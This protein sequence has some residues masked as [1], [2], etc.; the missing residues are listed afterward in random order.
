MLVKKSIVEN[1][2]KETS[3]VYKNFAYLFQ[4]PLWKKE[5]PNGFTVCPYFWMSMFSLFIFRPFV[6]SPIKY[7]LLPLIHA[8][9]KP[10]V[11]ADEFLF[12]IAKRILQFNGSYVKGGGVG[13]GIVLVIMAVAICG[14]LALI[15]FGVTS[16]Y[17]AVCSTALGL[18]VFYSAASF[19]G[20]LGVLGLH[21]WITKTEC[22]TMYYLVVWLALY[23]I[24]TFVFI[25]TEAISIAGNV[26]SAIGHGIGVTFS[27]LGTFFGFYLIGAFKFAW[28]FLKSLF[29]WQPIT[30]FG[31][32]WWVYIAAITFA[33][34]ISEKIFTHMALKETTTL[35]QTDPKAL[36][37]RFRRAWVNIFV[38]L[39][40][41]NSYWKT[42]KYL[43]D[44]NIDDMFILRASLNY[45]NSL[46]HDAFE[47]M[48]G[49]QLDTL[50]TTY[51]HIPDEKNFLA[52]MRKNPH[53]SSRYRFYTLSSKIGSTH[54]E[55]P[56]S[57][58]EYAFL[59]ELKKVIT[60]DAHVMALA[61]QYRE[62]ERIR[63]ENLEAKKNAWSHVMCLK[64]TTAIAGFVNTMTGKIWNGIKH[65]YTMTATLA[66]YLWMLIKAKKQGAC[67]YFPFTDANGNVKKN[68]K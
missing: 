60:T 23:V 66:A 41:T 7:V 55:L 1:W 36:Q 30:A 6:V 39:L 62:D 29:A 25:P 65:I 37:S 22:K 48:W 17:L 63:L 35:A 8:I 59:R 51:P 33:G 27:T 52:E 5:V 15:A 16:T 46:F 3:L 49:R 26:L 34:W 28:L 50:Q 11:V 56:A 40:N 57:I 64:V 68:N 20:L 31:L 61:N 67:P 21:K 14:C 19:I 44:I 4:N 42:N 54:P 2:Y 43:G 13:L 12:K 10:A 24:A 9:G 38:E 47:I 32:P 53:W 18:F 58:D 45:K